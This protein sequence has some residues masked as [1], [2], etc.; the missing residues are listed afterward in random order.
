MANQHKIGDL[1]MARQ[2]GQYL[3]QDKFVFGIIVD[4]KP[5]MHKYKV[6]WVDWGCDDVWYT[7]GQ[8][9]TWKA[10]LNEKLRD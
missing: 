4:E 2:T 5:N 8:V 10:I 9:E 6:D 1:V 7:N 3:R